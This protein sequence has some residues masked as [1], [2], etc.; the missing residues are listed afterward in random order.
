MFRNTPLNLS[1]LLFLFLFS[2]CKTTNSNESRKISMW[3]TT[4]DKQALFTKFDDRVVE[5]SEN[6]NNDLIQINSSVT[7]QEMDGFGYTLTGGSA[8]HL[9]NMSTS[10]RANILKELFG[11][12]E[13]SIGVSYL[14]ISIGASDLDA[15]A[16]TYNDIPSNQIDVELSG[17]NLGSSKIDLIPILNEILAINPDIKIIG[18]PWTAPAWMKTNNSLIGGEL[19]QQYFSSYA[20]YFVKY[21]EAM[22]VEGIQI[23]AITIQNEPLNPFNNPSMEMKATTQ[24]VFIKDHLGPAFQTA[25]IETKIIIYDHNPDEI[26]YPIS[27]LNDPDAK[28]FIDG[29]AF[30]LYAGDISALSTLKSLHPDKNIYFTEQ[31]VQAGASFGGDLAWHTRNLIVGASRNWSKTVLEWNLASNATQD[32]HTSGGCDDCLG[33]ITIQNEEV[34]RNVAYYIIAHASKYVRPGSVRIESTEVEGLPNV[35]FKNLKGEIILIVLNDSGNPKKFDISVDGNRYSLSLLSGA[36]G[37]I[38]F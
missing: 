20:N 26:S 12:E 17:F 28:Q 13:N 1:A 15:Q 32:P 19:S 16:F 22:E 31:W 14:R 27:I 4:P 18:S 23:D 25:G 8:Q 24:A 30:H 5:A 29:T 34:T 3:L 37:T 6:S 33:A 21:I 9:A 2:S 36:V 7:F 38:I 11:E 35:A 10:T